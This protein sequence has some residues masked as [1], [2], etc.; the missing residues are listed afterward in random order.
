MGSN[1]LHSSLLSLLEHELIKSRSFGHSLETG[2]GNYSLL[3]NIES[4]KKTAVDINLDSTEKEGI[5]FIKHNVLHPFTGH[6]DLI[7][8][9][10][11]I[12]CLNS[13][14]DIKKY[15]ENV[16]QALRGDGLFVLETMIAGKGFK[17]AFSSYINNEG[18][19]YYKDQPI[20]TIL[21]E[22]KIENILLSIGFKIEYFFI[23]FSKRFHIEE[24]DEIDF[25]N[26]PEVLQIICKKKAS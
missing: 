22:R 24:F 11:L 10:H 18:I 16:H 15:C 12:H 8:D 14:S 9:S 5:A 2:C 7:I 6:Y 13:E 21:S 23:P 19:L 17:E 26:H 1:H 25:Q 3:K 20:R 4:K